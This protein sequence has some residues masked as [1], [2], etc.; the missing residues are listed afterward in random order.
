MFYSHLPITT[1]NKKWSPQ[2]DQFVKQQ[3]PAFAKEDGECVNIKEF[4]HASMKTS[5]LQLLSFLHIYLVIFGGSLTVSEFAQGYRNLNDTPFQ[6]QNLVAFNWT[7]TSF[8]IPQ[9][10]HRM[11]AILSECAWFS[12]SLFNSYFREVLP[13]RLRKN[14]PNNN[15]VDP[16]AT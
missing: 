6:Y 3:W 8:V 2:R 7:S 4:G 14:M 16:M 15:K 1:R 10:V 9:R 13:L 11:G 12:F 5:V